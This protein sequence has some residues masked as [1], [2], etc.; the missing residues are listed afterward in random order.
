MTECFSATAPYQWTVEQ[1]SR[2]AQWTLEQYNLPICYLYDLK[3]DGTT[4]CM[5]SQEEFSSRWPT[6][7]QYLHAQLE[8]W[9]GGEYTN[10]S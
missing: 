6:F 3:I 7:G 4:L 10:H 9:K 2:W 1:V 8:V 5:L